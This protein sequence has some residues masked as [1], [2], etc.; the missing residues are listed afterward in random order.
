M[1]RNTAARARAT[2]VATSPPS[3]GGTGDGAEALSGRLAAAE[4]RAQILEARLAAAK[5]DAG[6]LRR[7]VAETLEQQEGAS[8]VELLAYHYARSAALD[9]AVHYL[10]Q[11]GGDMRL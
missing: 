2:R 4:A 5:Q 11:A 8:P 3:E 7:Q 6:D 1:A 10:E 9:K